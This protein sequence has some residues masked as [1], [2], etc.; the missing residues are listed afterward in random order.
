MAVF[1]SAALKDFEV[2]DPPTDSISCLAWSPAVDL[3]A[4]GSWDCNVSGTRSLTTNKNEAVF[5]WFSIFYMRTGFLTLSPGTD[6]RSGLK[7]TDSW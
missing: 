4:V 2:S 1:G 3:L 5:I 6:L 7:R